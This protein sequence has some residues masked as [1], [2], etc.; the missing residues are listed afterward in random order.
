MTR[1]GR[2]GRRTH[3][4][5]VV[6][7]LGVLL[8]GCGGTTP[9]RASAHHTMPTR[10]STRM[11]MPMQPQRGIARGT[12]LDRNVPASAAGARLVDQHGRPVTLA[13]LRGRIVVVGPLLSGCPRLAAATSR[14]LRQVARDAVRAEV[15]DRISVLELAVRPGPA[16]TA[17]VRAEAG[18]PARP[19]NWL[20][21]TGRPA[22]VALLWRGL[23]IAASCGRDTVV[24]LD[25]DGRV[26]WSTAGLP[27]DADL[28]DEAVGYVYG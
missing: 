26:R 10:M 1:A 14:R 2:A 16:T 5:A 18:R 20:L 17:V 24:V 4:V 8:T 27:W 22:A 11:S 9:H 12:T 23:G 3:A 15:G 7:A 28:L 19:A 13:S 25:P 21:A 6:V